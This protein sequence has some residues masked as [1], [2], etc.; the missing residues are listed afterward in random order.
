MELNVFKKIPK[1]TNFHKFIIFQ[2]G[3]EDYLLVSEIIIHKFHKYLCRKFK[4]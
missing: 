1:K 3:N 2:V 4:N